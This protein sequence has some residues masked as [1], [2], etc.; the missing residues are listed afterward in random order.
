MWAPNWW[1]TE[2]GQR[3][4][5]RGQK[6]VYNKVVL[7]LGHV[8]SW[9]RLGEQE[10]FPASLIGTPLCQV[11]DSVCPEL[12]ICL[13]LLLMLFRSLVQMNGLCRIHFVLGNSSAY[14]QWLITQLWSVR[15]FQPSIFQ[16]S[17]ASAS[18]SLPQSQV[19][20]SSC[21]AFFFS[22]IDNKIWI[23]N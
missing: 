2:A 12:A 4:L 22:V 14:W 13:F 15:N 19:I 7:W 10:W 5:S 23:D 16:L 17:R 9:S 11:T 8:D 6:L 18:S 20:G 21:S 1:G 3:S